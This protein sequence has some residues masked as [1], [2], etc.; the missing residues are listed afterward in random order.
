MRNKRKDQAFVS[1]KYCPKTYEFLSIN[2]N[3]QYDKQQIFYP[4]RYVFQYFS[5]LLILF[6]FPYETDF[7]CLQP[8]ESAF[9]ITGIERYRSFRQLRDIIRLQKK[10][11]EGGILLRKD[12]GL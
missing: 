2:D 3:F 6:L 4:K 10:I 11:I 1:Q 7:F 8:P 9:H 5:R 12:K